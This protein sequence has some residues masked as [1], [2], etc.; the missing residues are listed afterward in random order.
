VE[1]Y[2]AKIKDLQETTLS[3]EGVRKAFTINAGREVRAIVDSEKVPDSEIPT[4]A[5]S[6]AAKVQE[7]GGYPG[8]IKVVTIRSTKATDYAR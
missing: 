4:L 3:F 2:L 6:I 7:K 5:S 8:K 1:R